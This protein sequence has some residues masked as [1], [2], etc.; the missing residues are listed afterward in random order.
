MIWVVTLCS[1]LVVLT[2][3]R[4]AL[5]PLLGLK[6]KVV[7]GIISLVLIFNVT[8]FSVEAYRFLPSVI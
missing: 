2:S 3:Q 8:F 7:S 1:I 5:P 6:C 4:I